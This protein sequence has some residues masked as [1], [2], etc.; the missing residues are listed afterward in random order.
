MDRRVAAVFAAVR[1]RPDLDVAH[2]AASVNLSIS[3]LRHLFRLETSLRLGQHLK[4]RRLLLAQ[5][6]LTTTFLSVKEVAVA[7]G[8]TNRSQ[9]ARQFRAAFGFSPGEYRRREPSN[10]LD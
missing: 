9:F 10:Q 8:F 5:R 1:E 3:R 4:H 7:S 6:L 2:L